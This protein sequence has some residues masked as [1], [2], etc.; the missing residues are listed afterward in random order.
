VNAFVQQDQSKFSSTPT[1]AASDP[2]K[3]ASTQSL[4]SVELLVA[5]PLLFEPLT[6]FS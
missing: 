5:S 3:Q 1:P 2:S 4:P 6:F